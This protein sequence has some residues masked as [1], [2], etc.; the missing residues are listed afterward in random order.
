V[1]AKKK[2]KKAKK[3]QIGQR[4]PAKMAEALDGLE[5]PK[6]NWKVVAQI[7]VGFAVLWVVAGMLMPYIGFWGIGIAG[8][9]TLVAIGFGLYIWR[10]MRKSAGIVDILKGATDEAGRAEAL[11]RL[12][13]GKDSDV[14]NK[15]AQAQLVMQQ[16]PKEAIAILESIDLDKTPR[17]LRNDVRGQLGMIYLVTNRAKDARALADEMKLDG[18]A[19]PKQKAMYAA[20]MAEAFA[21]TG[22]VDEAAKILE[23][24]DPENETYAEMKPLLYRA[25]VYTYLKKKKKG[26]ARTAMMRLARHDPNQLGAFLQKGSHPQ[27][28]NLA[29]EVAQKEGL[30]PKQKVQMRMR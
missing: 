7:G 10:L 11:A 3:P 26:R 8:V 5:R 9:L 23:A 17:L 22:K 18:Q 20:V 2:K 21:R 6:M 12:Q 19:Q 28:S 25:Q 13:G 15:L 4:D 30:V 27:V 1:A 24:F 16:D 14:M 29:R